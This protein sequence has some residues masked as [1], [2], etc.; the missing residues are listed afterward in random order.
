MLEQNFQF[1]LVSTD[2]LLL[3]YLDKTVTVERSSSQR[4]V[5]EDASSI[6]ASVKVPANGS[7]TLRYGVRYTW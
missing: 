6:A 2:K 1:D 4:Y 3:K 5:K 7:S